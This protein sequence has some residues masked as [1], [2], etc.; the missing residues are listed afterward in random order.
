MKMTKL[1][2]IIMFFSSAARASDQFGGFQEFVDRG[3]LKPFTRDLGSIL[4]AASFHSGRSLGL[5]GFDIGARG[6]LQFKPSRGDTVLTGRGV[7][8]F[9]L[10][11]VQA[12][13]G[14]PFSLDGFIRGISYQGLTIAGGGLRY[15]ILKSADTP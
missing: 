13:I 6:G 9:G 1:A 3:S 15:S 10:P 2:V 12:E 8:A 5:T 14:L 4:G 11:W 7:K